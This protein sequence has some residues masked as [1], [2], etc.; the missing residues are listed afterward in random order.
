MLL[1]LLIN[2]TYLVQTSHDSWPTLRKISLNLSV[3][4]DFDVKRATENVKRDRCNLEKV[5]CFWPEVIYWLKLALGLK[6]LI[7]VPFCNGVWHQCPTDRKL[8]VVRMIS[9]SVSLSFI[10]NCGKIKLVY[11]NLFTDTN[12]HAN[13]GATCPSTFIAKVCV[14]L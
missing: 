2:W 11:I 9:G 3:I 14:L 4:F 13:F 12:G 7:W 8:P 5:S 10:V 1:I 6:Y